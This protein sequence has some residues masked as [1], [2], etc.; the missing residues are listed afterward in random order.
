[1]NHTYTEKVQRS[2]WLKQEEVI[3]DSFFYIRS[4]KAWIDSNHEIFI[5]AI[6]GNS[7]DPNFKSFRL[8]AYEEIRIDLSPI[9]AGKI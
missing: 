6:G 7:P 4:F 9:F 2:S 5:S 8:F 3:L 1:M